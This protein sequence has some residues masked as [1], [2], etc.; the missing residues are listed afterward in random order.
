[1]ELPSLGAELELQL[2]AYTTATAAQDPIHIFDLRYSSQQHQIL[3]PLSKDRDQAC[4]LMD[5]SRVL[6]LMSHKG[7]S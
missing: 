5:T 1:M 7:K 2:L 6:N 3:K 4:F